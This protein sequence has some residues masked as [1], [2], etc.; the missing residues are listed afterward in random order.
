MYRDRDD[1]VGDPRA[2]TARQLPVEP[3]REFTCPYPRTDQ[4][5]SAWQKAMKRGHVSWVLADQWS[6]KLGLHPAE[7]WGDEWFLIRDSLH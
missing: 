4:R 1:R 5:R 3:L 2:M 7:N 6:V